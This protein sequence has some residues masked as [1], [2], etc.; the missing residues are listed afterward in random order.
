VL[1]FWAF[2]LLMLASAV[3][4]RIDVL[5]RDAAGT[6]GAAFSPSECFG[7]LGLAD[8]GLFG[9]DWGGIDDHAAKRLFAE[10]EAPA[11]LEDIAYVPG[12][13]AK[14]SSRSPSYLPATALC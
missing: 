8:D 5:L 9:P 3:G 6:W 7:F 4:D 14:R 13:V 12:I 1:P 2:E 11:T 10:F